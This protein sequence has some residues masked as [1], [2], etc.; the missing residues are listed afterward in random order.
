M[1]DPADCDEYLNPFGEYLYRDEGVE[2]VG[3]KD[4]GAFMS[5][6]VKPTTRPETDGRGRPVDLATKEIY[7]K[8]NW[9]GG[10]AKT[11]NKVFSTEPM[12]ELPFKA[13]LETAAE[14]IK[15]CGY[16]IYR[17]RKNGLTIFHYDEL[18]T[19]HRGLIGGHTAWIEIKDGKIVGRRV[20]I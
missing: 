18:Y 8:K 7:L 14:L 6:T 9:A 11:F 12:A 16:P 13:K 1:E 19:P 17:C 2:I 5:V 15:Y 4:M 10:F 3:L 20:E